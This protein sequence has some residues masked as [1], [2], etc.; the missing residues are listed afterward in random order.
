MSGKALNPA[1]AGLSPLKLALLAQE[2]RE[3]AEVLL[4]ANPI[5]I[6]GMACRFPG[7][8]DS[9]E[10]FWEI[11]RDGRDVVGPIPPGRWDVEASFDPDPATPGKSAVREGG[12]IGPIDGFD[13]AFFGILPREA[14]RMDPQQRLF[15]EIAIEAF[16]DAG[17]PRERLAGSR[18][19]VFV[20]SYHNDYQ[21][22]E[23]NDPETIDART[24]TG[25]VHSVLANRLSY[26]L[27]L[28]GPSIS[29]DT[30]CSSSLVAIHLACESLRHGESDIA[31]AG[32]VSLMITP[33]LM[34]SLSK[35]GFMAPDGRSK[36]FDARADGFGRGEGC[37]VIILKRL[38]DAVSDGDRVLAV[39]RGSAVNQDGHSTVLAAPNGL[40]QQALIRE[41]LANAQ[42]EPTSIGFIEAHG[43]GTALG[44]PI[45]VEALATT[46]GM[47][48]ATGL[49]C[50]LG[51]AK[52][53]IGHM[54][55]AAGVGGVI[56]SLLMFRHGAIP[57]QAHFTKLSPHISLDGTRLKIPTAL[58]P[59]PAGAQP[60][61]I[62][63]SGFGVGGTN[64][65]VVMEEPPQLPPGEGPAKDAPYLLPLSAQSAPALQAL[66]RKWVDLLATS[67]VHVADLCAAAAQRRSHYDHRVAFV[68]N[69][70][71]ELEA[72]VRGYLAGES[73]GPVAGRLS[74]SGAPRLA[75]VFSG[76]GPQ[77]FAMGRELAA[78]E[79][80]FQAALAQ[81]D[82]R[83]STLAPWSLLTELNAT[84]SASR[85]GETEIAQPA[86]FAIQVALAALWKSWGF[87]PDGVVGHSVGEIAALHVAG[88]IDLDTAVRIV[89]HRARIMQRATGQGGMAAVTLS[90]ADAEPLVRRFG[91]SL[92]VGA[93]NSPRGVVLSGT[94]DSLN[95]ALAE[96][97]SRGVTNRALPVNY[98]F[99]SAQMRPLADELVAAIGPIKAQ[100]PDTP[101]Y[102]TV[103]GS[104][105]GSQA[106]DA[107][108]VGRNVRERVRFASAIDSMLEDG[109]NAFLEIAPHPVLATSLTECIAARA[110]EASVLASLRR[111]RPERETML[112]A[113][114]GL[115][116]NVRSPQW[117]VVQGGL[118]E[119]CE[120]P[121]YP[122]QRQRY[123]LRERPAQ[124]TSATAAGIASGDRNELLGAR[125]PTAAAS[126]FQ[127]SWPGAAP[128]WL[129]DH[130]VAGRLLVPGAAMLEALRLAACD[131]L[132]DERATVSDFVI[133]HPLVLG[134]QD[135]P[136]MT[137]Q[138]AAQSP[139][140]G[141]TRVT[142]HEAVSRGARVTWRLI[143]SAEASSQP[144]APAAAVAPPPDN[145]GAQDG[146]YPAFARLGVS[147]G[148][149]FQTI[150]R[151]DARSGGA[152]ASLVR[153]IEGDAAALSL[154]PTVLDGAFQVCAIAASGA[155]KNLPSELLLPLSVESYSVV[156]PIPDR[157]FVD[158]T[159]DRETQR[160]SL[161]AKLAFRSGDGR[162]VASV[163]G[164]RFTPASEQALASLAR[165]D[166]WL[167][168]LGWLPAPARPD[169]SATR[170][171]AWILLADDGG[172][173]ES[174]AQALTANG[175]RCL[176][177][178]AGSELA[179][180]GNDHWTID[181]ANPAHF[182]RVL[183]ET[184]WRGDLPLVSVVHL[185]SLDLTSGGALSG[186]EQCSAD[187]RGSV[188]AMHLLQSMMRTSSEGTQLAFV[189]SGAQPAGSAVPRPQA[190]G[191]WGL[192]ATAN[193]ELP[194]IDCRVIDLDAD[195]PSV[196]ITA[197]AAEL[198]ATDSVPR[199]LILRG[200]RRLTPQLQSLRV[201]KKAEESI[202]LQP[203]KTRTLDSLR[204]QPITAVSP[205][206]GK[207]RVRVHAAGLNFRDVMVSLGMYPGADDV[208]LGAEC[209]GVV[210]AVGPGVT[211]WVPGDRVFGF[212][213]RALASEVIVPAAF[214]ARLPDSLTAAQAAALPA[215]YLTALYGLQQVAGIR[216]GMKV[217]VHA[218]A[219]GVGM[220]AI[221]LAK[222]A[223]AEIFA[224]AGSASKR[225]LLQSLGVQHV[226]DSRTLA[227][228]QQIGA[229]TGGQGVD[230]VLNSLSGE[231]IA[232][233]VSVL[234]KGG[235]FLEL[236]K[237]DI[238]SAEQFAK[239][240]PDARYRAYDFGAVADAERASVRPMLDE[241]IAG[242]EAG[243]LQPLPVRVFDFAEA[244]DAFR[245]MAQA[246]HVGKLVL[247]APAGTG[248]G[249]R[250][251]RENATYWI[252]GGLGALGLHTA[253]WLV[254]KGARS[255]VLTARHSPNESA[256]RAIAQLRESGARVEVALA[257]AGDSAAMSDVL[258]RIR[259]TLP[260][261]RGVIHA[262]GALDDG[263]LMQ[264]NLARW[265]E[266]LA[267]KAH[268]ARILD[269]ITRGLPLDFFILYSAAG[270]LLGPAGQ[271]AYASANAELDALA[272]RRRACGFPATSVA[273][274][275]WADSG[276]AASAVSSGSDSWAE[277]GLGWIK[278]AEA[279][280]RLESLLR[281]GATHAAVLPI[282]WQKF[283]TKLGASA[284]D[285]SYFSSVIPQLAQAAV[286]EV[287]QRQDGRLE[288]WK[289]APE[290]ER[291]ALLATHLHERALSVLG[292]DPSTRL[293]VRA[294][295]KDAGLDSLMAVELRNALV[296]SIGHSLPATLLF[297]YP[298]LDQLAAY[299]M[300]TLKLAPQA[301]PVRPVAPVVAAGVAALSDEEAEAQ[302][303]AELEG[304]ARSGTK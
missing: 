32:G 29:V 235:C 130:R 9:P 151:L 173:A 114:A 124:S 234:A 273:W 21:L 150:E 199:R 280:A 85:L 251:V 101:S 279:F 290:S 212:A 62:G 96:L 272:H 144:A 172:V 198:G 194:D 214:L 226:F 4:R 186:S 249:D 3:Q 174:L 294:P 1:L 278:P 245:F 139:V 285:R 107:A 33:D 287:A 275:M 20:A 222:R 73:N 158:V 45:E 83:L 77:W 65:H 8:A 192:A 201:S 233:S 68:G 30:A 10:A 188:S 103:T 240:R 243:E 266:V 46:L 143:A 282:D 67:N 42:V 215:T 12:F 300:K 86:I 232:A 36:T 74:P 239:A 288:Q 161:V 116:A 22:L 276:M 247:R 189:T 159:V 7:G 102:S 11:L 284:V 185:W 264:Q 6:V 303:L 95:K 209:A 181:P 113:C 138:V 169:A 15:M 19:G 49:P 171:G 179:Q 28:R 228:A 177:V 53:N 100:A 121:S 81:V 78:R 296:R 283:A 221:Q 14:E 197:L 270:L 60:R 196:D 157:V 13:A 193:A 224:T 40:A 89:Y 175:A 120:L 265:S 129:A 302:L 223:G 262:A 63:T 152:S 260:P 44:D 126:L 142:L 206:N 178:Q 211:E 38:A 213:Q 88:A 207:V 167:Y 295:L 149:G 105:V 286:V 104:L 219:G 25:T 115:Y 110:A 76:Q 47:P 2:A 148:E 191:L 155:S 56:K 140:D 16:D 244:P 180:S 135:D 109:F 118:A 236:G 225:S 220:A 117:D 108:Y 263:V 164:A 183:S 43:T 54:E 64:A 31:V 242:I 84:E 80:V 203:G 112:L 165:S 106:V 205:A 258:G 208:P 145:L 35:V 195:A 238:W 271:G 98:A 51:A 168:Q 133:H 190:A 227:F 200:A 41:A 176:R 301:A 75:F 146:I 210:E 277:R 94:R 163:E 217:L 70:A 256:E 92:S 141:K 91:D 187:L 69:T 297:D 34:I 79:P 132:G 261:L 253:R 293:D 37:G 72:R 267:G 26:A 39:V 255:L 154:H 218:G 269:A 97:E 298:S 254:D 292:L 90:E 250:L 160:G 119:P 241:V 122:W 259:R 304:T 48:G 246:R 137:W 125:I 230:I 18:T 229:Q 162:L 182:D 216:R 156:A 237:R 57:P 153:R 299:L 27:D 289:N 93:V 82:A 136:A 23:Y 66:A 59:W 58:T 127:S 111:N 17:L 134:E 123:W 99:H 170:R 274:G 61:R 55:A 147:F 184:R 24:L 71:Q 268:G 281:S 87:E 257:D 50:F 5:A 252:T 291:R 131:A 204:W 248:L 202:R 52:A 166:D 231:F 128:A